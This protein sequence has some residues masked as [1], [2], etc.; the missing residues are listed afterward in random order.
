MVKKGGKKPSPN[1]TE[2]QMIIEQVLPDVQRLSGGAGGR[3][4]TLVRRA[5]G[6]IL[7]RKLNVIKTFP[8][9]HPMRGRAAGSGGGF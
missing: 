1:N 9:A 4:G 3:G 5:S 8:D 2:R 6:L 7:F